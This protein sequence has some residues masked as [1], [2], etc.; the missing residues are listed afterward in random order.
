MNELISVIIPAYNHEKYVQDTIWSIINQ[1]YRNIELIIVN[2]GSQD[3]THE[4]ILEL[5]EE[6]KKR[7]INFFCINKENNGVAEALNDGIDLATGKYVYLIA[8]DDVAKP[9]AVDTLYNFIKDKPKYAL[10]VGDDDFIDS[11]SKNVAINKYRK[12]I[13]DNE[14]V[15]QETFTKLSE[16]GKEVN[17]D[18]QIDFNSEYF[19]NYG[20]LLYNCY[21]PNG[22]L[23][24]REAIIDAGKYIKDYA[25]DWY[26][27]LQLSKKYKFKYIDKVLCSY[28]CHPDNSQKNY[29]YM[30][31]ILTNVFKGE[32]KY[33]YKN[34]YKH[35]YKARAQYC[36]LEKRPKYLQK[37]YSALIRI[38]F[39][40][41]YNFKKKSPAELLEYLH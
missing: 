1:S 7:F 26:M 28:R 22:Y 4:K 37:K 12:I 9:E 23:I 33:A 35:L 25:E 20:T 31:M 27:F 39:R 8:S 30:L 21:L 11:E 24:N 32:K 34:G 40:D 41:Y 38:F 19:G 17:N 15:E 14:N 2:D 16:L 10:V 29:K 18:F 36:E 5:Q 13:I 3:K 6:C